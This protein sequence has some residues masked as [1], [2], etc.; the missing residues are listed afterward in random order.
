MFGDGGG[1]AKC[2]PDG[3][4]RIGGQQWHE[5]RNIV[6]A[7]VADKVAHI[8]AFGAVG[9]FLLKMFGRRLKMMKL[10]PIGG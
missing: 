7:E 2:A 4:G 6:C 8:T 1:G 9:R 3:S 5:L 10:R